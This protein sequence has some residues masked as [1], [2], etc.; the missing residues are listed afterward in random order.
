[1][2]P[3]FVWPGWLVCAASALPCFCFLPGVRFHACIIQILIS[4]RFSSHI[5]SCKSKTRLV[6]KR[7]VVSWQCFLVKASM[8]TTTS[9]GQHAS[10]HTSRADGD[11][12]DV[13]NDSVQ[14]DDPLGALGA[15]ASLAANASVDVI[16]CA[17]SDIS[18]VSVGREWVSEWRS[19]SRC[20][21]KS[22]VA[23]SGAA[24]VA[25][26]ASTTTPAVADTV[27]GNSTVNSV[28]T[29]TCSDR[30]VV[31]HFS[32]APRID[33]ASD[34]WSAARN[35]MG[36]CALPP[37]G[38]IT[39]SSPPS[40]HV[41]SLLTPP[42]VNRNV[43]G[44]GMMMAAAATRAP[45]SRTLQPGPQ[46]VQTSLM[47]DYGHNVSWGSHGYRCVSLC[48]NIRCDIKCVYESV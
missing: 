1:M 29:D 11:D 5:E 44:S 9:P 26:A 15:F 18:I 38:S 46:H 14:H 6:C 12:L 47:N 35:T 30:D 32:D 20:D 27:R 48:T 21:K 4:T 43:I 3:S 33:A 31:R 39:A 24:A 45:P 8:A 7:G 42:I 40:W 13:N 19:A 23:S 16:T 10:I 41:S 28:S 36:R 22:A 34:T 17:G 2:N 37:R 25:N